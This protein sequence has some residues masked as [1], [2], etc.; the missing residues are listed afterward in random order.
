MTPRRLRTA[1]PALLLPLALLSGCDGGS[2]GPDDGS[3]GESSPPASASEPNVPSASATGAVALESP[4]DVVDQDEIASLMGLKHVEGDPI[5]DDT[6]GTMVCSF[7]D[8]DHL[9]APLLSLQTSATDQFDQFLS[10]SKGGGELEPIDVPG[11]DE[12]AVLVDSDPDFPGV[13]IVAHTPGRL[14]VAV[15]GDKTVAAARKLGIGAITL[16][17]AGSA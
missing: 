13:T 9:D 16:L 10:F 2:G 8:T 14:H 7:F 12:A 6:S 11:A 5:G 4:C 17:V 1:L 3:S 15:V